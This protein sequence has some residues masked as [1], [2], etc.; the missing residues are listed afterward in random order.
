MVLSYQSLRHVN[1]P[2]KS[3]KAPNTQTISHFPTQKLYQE[4]I[5]KRTQKD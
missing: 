3:R 1:N 2:I 4:A 5:T